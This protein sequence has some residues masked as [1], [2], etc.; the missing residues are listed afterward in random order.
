MVA[1]CSTSTVSMCHCGELWSSGQRSTWGE[2][3]FLIVSHDVSGSLQ[4]WESGDIQSLFHSPNMSLIKN[5]KK[6][7]KK[8]WGDFA[9][10]PLKPIFRWESCQSQPRCVCLAVT[11]FGRHTIFVFG[12]CLQ[13][14]WEQTKASK[15]EK[16]W[17]VWTSNVSFFSKVAIVCSIVISSPRTQSR[18][19][20]K[21]NG[22]MEGIYCFPAQYWTQDVQIQL[23]SQKAFFLTIGVSQ[24]TP[25]TIHYT[26]RWQFNR[27]HEK[28]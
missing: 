22:T 23:Q 9:S 2:T 6:K 8:C 18:H 25:C 20:I 19:T 27:N 10:L 4:V 1:I 7:R 17:H 26:M 16:K 14:R 15:P 13:T 5:R 11:S 28:K 21:S 3:F 24:Y 12:G